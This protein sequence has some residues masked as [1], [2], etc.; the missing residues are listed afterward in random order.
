[1]KNYPHPSAAQGAR[2]A[3]ATN[4]TGQEPLRFHVK[5][6]IPLTAGMQATRLV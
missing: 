3:H 1:M 5:A 4:D 2:H 6:A